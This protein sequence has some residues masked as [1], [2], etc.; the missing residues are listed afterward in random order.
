MQQAGDL[1][2]AQQLVDSGMDQAALAEA[3]NERLDVPV[4][5]WADVAPEAVGLAMAS[6]L[7]GD[8]EVRESLLYAVNL[9][10]DADT[11][12][13]ITGALLGAAVGVASLPMHWLKAVVKAPEGK[14][15]SNFHPQRIVKLMIR[16]HL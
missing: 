3:L 9:G 16:G 13:A 14:V 12:A 1:E 5:F 6:L 11:N 2:D 10:R 7:V 15:P 4:Y 8:G